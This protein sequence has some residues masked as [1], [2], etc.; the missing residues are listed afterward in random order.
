MEAFEPS[1]W[2]LIMLGAGVLV[3][4]E[5]LIRLLVP[6]F[7]RRVGGTFILA[8]VFIAVGLGNLFQRWDV[9]WPMAL[10]VVGAG[11]L[12]GGLLRKRQ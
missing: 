12:F 8:A 7:N 2:G 4:V 1:L 10:I 11:V 3:L 6:Q 5:A 9:I